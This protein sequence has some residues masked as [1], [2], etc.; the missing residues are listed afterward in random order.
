VV[1]RNK[2]LVVNRDTM[3]MDQD[4]MTDTTGRANG[5][6]MKTRNTRESGG[7]N[8]EIGAEKG[9]G[10]RAKIKTENGAVSDPDMDA[11]WSRTPIDLC[12]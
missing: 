5:N 7:M 10:I 9:E 6:K 3:S 2:S 1:R 11:H 12:S 4:M 8:P